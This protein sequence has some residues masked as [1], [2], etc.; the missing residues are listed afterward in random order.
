VGSPSQNFGP[1]LALFDQTLEEAF[2]DIDPGHAPLGS[3]IMVQ[4]RSAKDKTKGGIAL[5]DE[6]RKTIAANTQ[7]GKVVAIGP[8]A[9]CNP[10]TGKPW[11]EGPWFKIGDFVR[12]PRHG[13]DSFEV[14]V[15]KTNGEVATFA[16]FDHLQ[17][18]SKVTGD[19][20]D[21]IAFV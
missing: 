19:P 13:G 18:S 15:P 17:F 14:P 1:H 2:P 20:L 3:K 6:V 8:V 11:P 16:V 4:I 10:N 21:I 5:P 9:F 12:C 7:V